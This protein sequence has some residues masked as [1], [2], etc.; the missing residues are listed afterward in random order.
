M[1]S[2]E[3]ARPR[4]TD[5]TWRL[6]DVIFY[7]LALAAL[8]VFLFPFWAPVAQSAGSE[9]A[10]PSRAL[11]LVVT[12]CVILLLLGLLGEAQAGLTA[13]TVAML[14]TLVGLNTALRVAENV[15]P[16]PG[17]FTPVFLLIALVGYT[18]GP[19]LGFLMGA[20]TLLVSGPFTAGGLG[21]W[22]PYQMVAAGWIG[23]AAAWLPKGKYG[24]AALAV[25]LTLWGWLYGALTNLYFWPYTL[26]AP[27]IGWTPGLGAAETLGRYARFYLVTSLLWDTVGAV[28][29]LAL[30][31]LAGRPLLEA[32]ERFRRRA[33]VIWIPA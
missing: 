6:G 15:V 10:E 2:F 13:L 12:L 5:S 9:S 22:T 29:N 1:S 26:L 4:I 11:L 27:D 25:Y 17:G 24:L 23:L 31:V 32:L 19:R 21:P 3:W 16:L 30:L 8:A 33:H 14:G 28:G 18:F 20:L 7:T